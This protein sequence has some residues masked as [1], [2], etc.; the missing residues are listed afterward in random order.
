MYVGEVNYEMEEISLC[1]CNNADDHKQ[2]DNII[3]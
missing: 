3:E 1:S 2:R